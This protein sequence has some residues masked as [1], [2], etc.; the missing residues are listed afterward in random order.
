[1]V[2]VANFA[3]SNVAVCLPMWGESFCSMCLETY[4]CIYWIGFRREL[5]LGEGNADTLYM[6]IPS[7]RPK[8]WKNRGKVKIN[9]WFRLKCELRLAKD[10][11]FIAFVFSFQCIGTRIQSPPCTSPSICPYTFSSSFAYLP[12]T[13]ASRV[14]C[15]PCLR[16]FLAR[17]ATS[18]FCEVLLF[19][20]AHIGAYA[21][22]ARTRAYTTVF[23]FFCC[24]I[25]HNS[26]ARPSQWEKGRS[27]KHTNRSR[28]GQKDGAEHRNPWKG[29]KMDF[30]TKRETCFTTKNERWQE[31]I[32]SITSGTI[33]V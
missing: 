20:L 33:R 21:T 23:L 14:F 18:F 3:R 6:Y 30:V 27:I 16:N 5:G 4:R 24:H 22:H 2:D 1:M 17:D 26:V 29:A 13:L 12:F 8:E 10:L 9:F 11:L 19:V 31:V 25:C 32:F 7:Y 15:L 28:N